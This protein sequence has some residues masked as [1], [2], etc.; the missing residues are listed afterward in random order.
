MKKEDE[1]LMRAIRSAR[2]K[3]STK[4]YYI[5]RVHAHLRGMFSKEAS[6]NWKRKKL[7]EATRQINRLW[8][9]D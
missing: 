1:D 8:D 4:E 2:A 7:R 6:I 5:E 3:G 9:C